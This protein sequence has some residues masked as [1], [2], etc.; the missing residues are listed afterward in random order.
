MCAGEYAVWNQS[1]ILLQVTKTQLVHTGSGA[2][3]ALNV[4]SIFLQKCVW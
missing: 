1:K 4:V 2:I 3:K